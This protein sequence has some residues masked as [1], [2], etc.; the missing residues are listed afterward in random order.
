MYVRIEWDA[1][2]PDKSRSKL[3]IYLKVMEDKYVRLEFRAGHHL[4]DLK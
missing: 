3:V 2:A 1:M 4:F